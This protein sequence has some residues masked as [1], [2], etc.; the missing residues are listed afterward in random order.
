MSSSKKQTNNLQSSRNFDLIQLALDM[1]IF[2]ISHSSRLAVRS[3]A[4]KGIVRNWIPK[5]H[6][7]HC[8]H[9]ISNQWALEDFNEIFNKYFSS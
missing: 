7:P 3:V 4:N 5:Q 8:P 2:L 1:N 9:E 6:I